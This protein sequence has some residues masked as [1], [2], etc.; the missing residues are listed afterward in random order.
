MQS[1][2]LFTLFAAFAFPVGAESSKASPDGRVRNVW[3]QVVPPNRGIVRAVTEARRCPI[4]H[5]DGLSER[6]KVRANP[7]EDY[8]VLVCE[9]PVPSAARTIEV[10]GRKLRP[11]PRSPRR[12]AVVGDTGCRMKDGD[13]LDDGF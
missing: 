8:N 10:A 1:L 4:A 6:M 3:V 7:N 13:A 2:L 12:I 9:L 5:F 11:V